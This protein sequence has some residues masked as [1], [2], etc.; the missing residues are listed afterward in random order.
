MVV[1]RDAGR[2]YS[3]NE[4]IFDYKSPNAVDLDNHAIKIIF[5]GLESLNSFVRT[6]QN[7]GN[8]NYE[9][10]VEREKITKDNAGTYTLRIELQD[11]LL[12]STF[13]E[14]TLQLVYDADYL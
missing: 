3:F 5:R 11:S 7:V 1:V 10:R 4:R 14:Q 2:D 13:W 6:W 8:R 9:I 12:Q